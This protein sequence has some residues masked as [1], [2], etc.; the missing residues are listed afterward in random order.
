M[1]LL[2]SDQLS[3]PANAVTQKIA[4]IGRT[5]SGKTYGAGV[6]VEQMLMAKTQ[7]VILDPVGVWYGLRIPAEKAR[8][9]FAIP[10]FGGLH[11]DIPL[12]STAGGLV[13]DLIVEKNLSIVLDVSQFESDADKARF[14]RAFADRFFFLKK[15]KPSPVHMVIEECQEF[16]PQEPRGD[17]THML[18]AFTR[19][20]KLGRNFGIGGSLITQRPQ[21]VSKK[22]LNQ[23]E[24]LFAFQMTGSH[25]RK[26]IK[27]WASDKG[28]ERDLVD[29]LPSLAVGNAFA[30]SPQWLR[31]ND[32][33]AFNKKLTANVSSTPDSN[34]RGGSGTP[35][36][37][38]LGAIAQE[39]KA[40]V[41]R[42]KENDPAELRAKIAGLRRE[43]DK[44]HSA[45]AVELAPQRIEVPV[46]DAEDKRRIETLGI[47]LSDLESALAEIG[48]QV[49]LA[50]S[51]LKLLNESAN[52]KLPVHPRDDHRLDAARMGL[53][54]SGDSQG[55]RSRKFVLSS[56]AR[57]EEKFTEQLT[58]LT[59]T[60]QKII[61]VIH[62]LNIRGI[63]ANRESVA[64]WLDIHPN[65]G[66]YGSD[67]AALRASGH[68]DGFSLPP[69]SAA[70]DI[71]TGLE[72]CKAPLEGTQR[73][74][75]DTLA[76]VAPNTRYDRNSLA[77]KLGI[78][79]N[80]GR[81][82]SDLARLRTMGLIPERG[83]IYLTEA[84]FR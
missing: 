35:A 28:V 53:F 68:I 41:E 52:K 5:G 51:E 57:T 44:I 23:T 40:T 45:K 19:M 70:R 3:L 39:M 78:H 83:D 67:L 55:E 81:Y 30:W 61:D 82:G 84:A 2:I 60:Q 27:E 74:I 18:H 33:I 24:L 29:E 16:I 1:K 56:L 62:M 17:E 46:F 63:P 71:P 58:G 43:L 11:G 37:I 26:A 9:G 64:R 77:A 73:T 4:F 12:E 69:V 34:V 10:V 42:A 48:V 38:D 66:R 47:E 22:V 59:G 36:T 80:G 65:G 49:K 6:M 21:E 50:A 32:K 7:V 25:E 76:N 54:H 31:F 15:A 14:A 20:W 79:P 13:A 75:I 8:D 72:A